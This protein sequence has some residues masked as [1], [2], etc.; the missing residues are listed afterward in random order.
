MKSTISSID[1]GGIKNTLQ[2]IKD[3]AP[4]QQQEKEGR[5][6][7][8]VASPIEQVTKSIAA[9]TGTTSLKVHT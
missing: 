6:Q 2:P 4:N 1:K 5:K 3:E 8:N 9:S 7:G